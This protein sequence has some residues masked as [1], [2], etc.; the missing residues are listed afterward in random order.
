MWTHTEICV[1]LAATIFV[2]LATLLLALVALFG[3]KFYPPKLEIT[4]PDPPGE[5]A[6]WKRDGKD[7]RA[8]FYHARVVNRRRWSPGTNL[9]LNLIAVEEERADHTFSEEWQGDVQIRWK[10]PS[11]YPQP[12]SIGKPVD[13]DLVSFD[14]DRFVSLHP[15]AASSPLK[16]DKAFRIRVWLQ[17]RSTEGD[18]LVT[19]FYISW[20]GAWAEAEKEMGKYFSIKPA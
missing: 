13:Y 20:N 19:R 16:W 5:L 1:Y 17:A 18:S 2:G 3:K 10:Y 14:E 6:K 9:S 12:N 15:I 7:H 8:W 4:L 11:H